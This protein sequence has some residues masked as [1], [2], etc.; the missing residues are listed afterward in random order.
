L[1]ASIQYD[2]V[3]QKALRDAQD[4][5]W[6]NLPPTHNLPDD[7][8]VF[9]LR[10]ILRAPA[11]QEAIEKGSDTALCF[12]LRAANRILCDKYL[13]LRVVLNRLWDVLDNNE[14]NRALGIKQNSRMMVWRKKPSA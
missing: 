5:L 9:A 8:A 3:I 13:P 14:L 2:R 1:P 10:K 12:V 11:A 4:I 6:V 7:G